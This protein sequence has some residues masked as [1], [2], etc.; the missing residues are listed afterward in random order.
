MR[1]PGARAPNPTDL[2]STR[3][4]I[5]A[6]SISTTA[7]VS[8]KRMPA[9]T[10]GIARGAIANSSRLGIGASAAEYVAAERIPGTGKIKAK[11]AEASTGTPDGYYDA[12]YLNAE[13]DCRWY[14]SQVDS[15][16]KNLRK[17]DNRSRSCF[18]GSLRFLING[19]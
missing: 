6:V 2:E 11:T 16:K 9:G 3:A 8:L 14:W 15:G 13:G 12:E 1:Y 7:S 5:N 17:L 18:R 4:S 10:N 19:R